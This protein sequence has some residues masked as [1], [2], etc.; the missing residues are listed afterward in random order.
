MSKEEKHKGP[1][2]GVTN[3]GWCS[4]FSTSPNYQIIFNPP[5]NGTI[6]KSGNTWPFCDQNGNPLSSPIPVGGPN[7]IQ[8]YI[9]PN[10]SGQYPFIP[11]P[12][13]KLT[14]KT[15]TVG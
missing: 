5:G 15:V 2:N 8:I 3:A 6:T 11:S 7:A 9:C 1:G 4:D 10:A 14:T 13:T 12:C